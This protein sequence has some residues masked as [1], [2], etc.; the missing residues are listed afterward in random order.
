MVALLALAV[1]LR[2]VS[3]GGGIYEITLV[4]RTWPARPD[5]IRPRDGGIARSHF[6]IPAHLIYEITLVAATII[7]WSE[8]TVRPL[9]LVA[10]G[11][12]LSMRIWSAMR[13]IP[14]ALRF[15]RGDPGLDQADA[16]RWV[17][18][19]RWRLLLDVIGGAA[20]MA[21]LI[22]AARL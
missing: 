8:G 1:A 14:L 7:S 15:E 5:I 17:R 13:F 18:G 22:A 11:A 6:W 2:F 16:E 21:A 9:L 19:S 20:V 4:D 12:Q 10:I 3:L